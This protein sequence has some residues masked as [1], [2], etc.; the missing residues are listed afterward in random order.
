M[1]TALAAYRYRHD[2]SSTWLGYGWLLHH[3]LTAPFSFYAGSHLGGCWQIAR[4]LDTHL[5]AHRS[6]GRYC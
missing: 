4:G 6:V 1:T 2:L 5:V 3:R